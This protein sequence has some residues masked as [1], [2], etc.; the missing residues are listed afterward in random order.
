MACRE[1]LGPEI[2]SQLPEGRLTS[3]DAGESLQLADG[4]VLTPTRSAHETLERDGRGN[5]RF[6][7][8]GFTSDGV[9]LWHSGDGI[10]FDGLAGDVSKLRPDIAL[11]PVNGRRPELGNN[12]VPGNFTLDEAIVISR[13][14]GVRYL[15]AHHY[16]LFDFNTLDPD[17]IDSRALSEKHPRLLRARDAIAFQWSTA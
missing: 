17:V 12:G 8:Y 3:V 1:I 4:L 11:M 7:G 14:A 13:Q 6:L 16:G 2:L 10:P 5:H 15:I 9:T